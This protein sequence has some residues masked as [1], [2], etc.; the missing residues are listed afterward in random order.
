LNGLS[1][2]LLDG[3]SPEAAELVRIHAK[4]WDHLY[5][6]W[7]EQTAL[8]EFGRQKTDGSLPATLTLQENGTLVG[9]VSVI[10]D[11]CEA[12]TDLNPWLGSL[13]VVPAKRGRGHGSRLVAAALELATRNGVDDL[14][15]FT[16]SAEDM[17]RRHG[18]VYFADAVTNGCPITIL[19]REL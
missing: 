1:L 12:R 6:R 2:T 16:E 3:S 9:S 4:E 18:F 11:D 17:F 15:V 13:Y 5:R 19:R 10:Y 7:D 14:Y 8:A